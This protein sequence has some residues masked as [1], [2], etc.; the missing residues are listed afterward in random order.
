MVTS[1][2]DGD[3]SLRPARGRPVTRLT[4]SA[5]VRDGADSTA[6]GRLRT[7]TAGG[8]TERLRKL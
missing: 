6:P 2:W 5:G 7:G 4:E 8:F 1:A 3:V